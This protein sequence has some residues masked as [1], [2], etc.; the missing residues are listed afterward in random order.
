MSA[1]DGAASGKW[2]TI[3][4][5]IV[6]L[7][8][9]RTPPIVLTAAEVD[10]YLN[11]IWLDPAAE[12]NREDIRQICLDWLQVNYPDAPTLPRALRLAV[13]V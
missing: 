12:N 3:V 7:G 2:N 8:A 9:Q 11:Q 4:N 5:G 6:N 10:A 13:A 1:P